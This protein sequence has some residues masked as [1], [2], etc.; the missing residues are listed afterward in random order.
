[1][2]SDNNGVPL[3]AENVA[4]FMDA[5]LTSQLAGY[6][7][8]GAVVAV[9]KDGEILF[10]GGYGYQ[11]RE[12]RIKMDPAVSLTR[13]GSI[14]KLFTW[15][16]VMQLYEQ[17]LLD[18]DAD[19]NTYLSSFQIPGTYE[20]PITMKHILSHTAGFEETALGYLITFDPEGAETLEY[21]MANYIPARVNPPGVVSSYSNYATA[22][23]GLIIQNLSGLSFNEYVAVSYTHLTLPTTS[24]V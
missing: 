24:R 17:G 14:S 6:N 18:L 5:Y 20:E 1:M 2:E 21:A 10:S 7:T 3:T 9:V 13:P 12:N 16:S 4:I 15:V 8:Q 23:A 11:D 19:V 22:L